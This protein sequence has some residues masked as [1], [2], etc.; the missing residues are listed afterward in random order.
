MVRS[1]FSLST[2]LFSFQFSSKEGLDVMLENGS[3]FIR[4]NPLEKWHPDVNL[5]KEDVR[6]V[7]V[8]V[9]LHGV[10]VTAFSEDGLIAIATKLG[11]LDSYMS[12]MCMQSWDMSS[13]A[14]AMT[15]LRADVE[16]KDN[17]MGF[18]HVQEE[19]PRNIG[20]GETKNLKK[21]S[22]TPKG[23]LGWLEVDDEG[24]PLKKVVSSGDYDS[25]DEVASVHNEKASFLAKNDGYGT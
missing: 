12:Y 10:P 16:L 2:G 3:W 14:R 23:V 11:T 6:T 5:L 13:Y 9:K 1:M 20:A 19:C 22:Q 15:G 17:I 7:L 24:K 4:N 21:H 25:E 8:W 18:G